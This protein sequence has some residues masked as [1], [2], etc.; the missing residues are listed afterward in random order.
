MG[1][2]GCIPS[3]LQRPGREGCHMGK[4]NEKNFRA[5]LVPP[6]VG[7]VAIDP[8]QLSGPGGQGRGG[9]SRTRTEETAHPC[10]Q[11]P[12]HHCP[13]MHVPP[14][15]VY[16]C[17]PMDHMEGTVLVLES[18]I[19]ARARVHTRNHANQSQLCSIHSLRCPNATCVK[20]SVRCV[21]CR[22]HKF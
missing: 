19:A 14:I 12:H 5:P 11:H 13:P 20:T 1:K 6:Y 2:G 10:P 15:H 17:V 4:G 8:W 3:T 16:V 21:P 9:G 22:S 18:K 7:P